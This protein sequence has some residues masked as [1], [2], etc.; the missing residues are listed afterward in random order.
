MDDARTLRYSLAAGARERSFVL[1]ALHRGRPMPWGADPSVYD[2]AAVEA[3]LRWVGSLFGEGRYF[4]LDARGFENVPPAPV[5]LASNHS[6]GT[7]IPDVW[8]FAVAWYRRFGAT[9]P[10]HVLTHE[11]ILATET[12]GRYFARRGALRSSWAAAGEAIS[13]YGRDV[14][15][16]PGGDLD[17]WRPHR[18][19]YRVEFGGRVGY[20][21]LALELGVPIVP[22]AN[23][24]PHETLWVISDG[25]WVARA[26]GLHALFRAEIW[27]LH[28]SLPWGLA[29]G[30]W[31]HVPLPARFSYRVGEPIR[32]EPGDDARSL[33]ARV[34]GAVQ[35]LLDELAT[36]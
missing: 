18:R 25:R 19:R 16:M 17:A 11:I 10:L 14:L 23:A 29:L 9:R 30:P 28:V 1:R 15:V 13:G 22:V 4:G 34:R 21:R 20:A 8:G 5:M 35:S 32:P 26:M 24:G 2:P 36:S 3:T 31:P 6:G 27:P 33:D 7:T 12:T